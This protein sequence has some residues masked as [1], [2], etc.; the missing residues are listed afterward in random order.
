MRRPGTLIVTLMMLFLSGCDL[1]Q[2]E[3]GVARVEPQHPRAKGPVETIGRGE[4]D[5]QPWKLTAYRSKD[6]ICVDLHMGSGSSG[7]CG[8]GRM[9]G[10]LS[11]PGIGWNSDMPEYAQLDGRVSERV[12]KL[13]ARSGDGPVEELPLHRSKRLGLTFFVAFAPVGADYELTAYDEAGKELT[14]K[15]L[16][17]NELK[18]EG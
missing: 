5:G 16:T 4:I 14:T 11:I 17:P 9:R 3:A 1:W 12:A 8:F 18:P 13:T 15:L 7:G 6:G 2:R 10:A